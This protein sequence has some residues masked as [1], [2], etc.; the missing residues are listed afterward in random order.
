MLAF[1]QNGPSK[2]QWTDI[3]KDNSEVA[4]SLSKFG[5]DVSARLMYQAY[6]V[7]MCNLHVLFGDDFPLFRDKLDLEQFQALISH[8]SA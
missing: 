6:I 1:L 3:A 5:V 7:T 8:K 4:T 2:D